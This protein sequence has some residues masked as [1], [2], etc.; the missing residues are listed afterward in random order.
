MIKSDTYH[1]T[2]T[3]YLMEQESSSIQVQAEGDGCC[4]CLQD[5]SDEGEERWAL[6]G[7]A[8]E[9]LLSILHV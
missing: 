1:D 6:Q 7:H 5:K 9:I 3:N 2:W 8:Q 4:C